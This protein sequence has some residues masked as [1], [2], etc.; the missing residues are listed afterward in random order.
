M[1]R[2]KQLPLNFEPPPEPGSSATQC[3]RAAAC[4]ASAKILPMPDAAGRIRKV[5]AER[6]AELLER[7]LR[8]TN[9][10]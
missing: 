6:E 2:D 3:S 4:A 5:A 1:D 10:F 8:R 9:Y 7:V